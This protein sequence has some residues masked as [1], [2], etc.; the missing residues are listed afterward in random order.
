MRPMD[1]GDESKKT[2]FQ[3][4]GEIN[5]T[6]GRMDAHDVIVFLDPIQEKR[7]PKLE[8]LENKYNYCKRV[9]EKLMRGK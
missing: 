6:V 4:E 3:C 8:E 1:L 9:I 2:E 7:D 5:D